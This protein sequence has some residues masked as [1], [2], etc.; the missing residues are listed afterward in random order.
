MDLK[1]MI[2]LGVLAVAPL[3]SADMPQISADIGPC[4]AEFTVTDAGKKPLYNAK[5]H[6]IIRYGFMSKRKTELEIGTD[7]NGQARFTGLPHEVKKPI[8]FTVRAQGLSK[9]VTHDPA[10]NCH[11]NFE[12]AL[13]GK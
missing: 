1:M 12:V 7:V 5:I 10:S 9:T 3:H 11:A 6:T 2:A 13:G 8:Q 4:T